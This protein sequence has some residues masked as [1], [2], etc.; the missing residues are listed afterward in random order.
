MK[1][2][3]MIL[4]QMKDILMDR[5]DYTE[6]QAEKWL[7]ENKGKTVYELLVMKK[8]LTKVE[9]EYRDVSCRTSIWHEEEY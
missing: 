1:S 6:A 4:L 5:K 2:K 7:E 8:E 3:N 9:Q